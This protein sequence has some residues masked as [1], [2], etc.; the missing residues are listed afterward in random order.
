MPDTEQEIRSKMSMLEM[1][2]A[3]IESYSKNAEVVKISIDEHKRAKETLEN[4]KGLKAGDEIL[5]PI[6]GAA[7]VRA[8]TADTKKGIIEVGSGVVFEEK[9]DKILDRLENKLDELNRT[10]NEI[11]EQI[12]QMD[13]QSAALTQEIQ[14]QYARLQEEQGPD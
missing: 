5:I 10:Q 4:Y 2:K 12:Y 14:E 7:F 8:K 11:G 1:Y 9:I 6:G 13:Q 3:R